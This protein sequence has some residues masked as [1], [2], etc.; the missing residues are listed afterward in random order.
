MLRPKTGEIAIWD[1]AVIY[2]RGGVWQWRFWVAA[3]NRQLRRSLKTGSE[4]LAIERAQQQLLEVL[5]QL[6]QGRQFFAITLAKAVELYLAERRRDVA[7]GAI[8]AGRLTTID[9]HLAHWLS[10]AGASTSLRDLD[11]DRGKGYLEYRQRQRAKNITI[12]HE[13]STVNAL[14][15]WLNRAGYA[16]TARMNWSKA[17]KTDSRAENQRRQTFTDSEWQRFSRA[18]AQ[19]PRKRTSDTVSDRQQRWTAVSFFAIA[20]ATGMRTGEQRQLR[21]TD[22]ATETHETQQLNRISIRAATSKVRMSREFLADT[23]QLFA[24]LRRVMAVRGDGLVFSLDGKRAISEHALLYHWRRMLALAEIERELV[25]YSLRHWFI[26]ERAAAGVAWP[27]IAQVCG[28]SVTQ[29]ERTY[30]HLRDDVRR[31]VVRA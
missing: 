9:T 8:V 6:A 24:R 25:P 31:A 21:W 14:M 26:T 4:S 17:P 1:R 20:A 23:V 12:Q 2:K 5:A 16:T 11:A 22:V 3:E 28:T 10:Y 19:Y 27:L 15:A 18:L 7:T 29:I 13:Q 30:F